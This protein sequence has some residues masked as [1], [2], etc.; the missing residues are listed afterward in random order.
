MWK[1]T[2][3]TV[4]SSKQFWAFIVLSTN[5][6]NTYINK[7]FLTSAICSAICSN[8]IFIGHC[9]YFVIHI[10]KNPGIELDVIVSNVGVIHPSLISL[11]EIIRFVIAISGSWF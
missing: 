5:W 1:I 4:Y 11:K 6:F 7:I 2:L 3:N 9:I 8:H 10:K